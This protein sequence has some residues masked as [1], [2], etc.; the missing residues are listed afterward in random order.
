MT[1]AALAGAALAAGAAAFALCLALHA[2][3]PREKFRRFH[4]VSYAVFLQLGVVFAVLLAFVFN[5]VWSDTKLLRRPS[6][7]NAAACMEWP[8]W[9][10]G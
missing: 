6:T 7:R 5:G 2:V 10:V 4:D 9:P 8:F 3:V 1:Y